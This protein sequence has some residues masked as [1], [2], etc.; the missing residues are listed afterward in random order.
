M[1]DVQWEELMDVY[2]FFKYSILDKLLLA[3]KCPKLGKHL[4]N[5]GYDN[6]SCR[7][8]TFLNPIH[9]KRI[10]KYNIYSGI[11]FYTNVSISTALQGWKEVNICVRVVIRCAYVT[12]NEFHNN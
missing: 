11:L 12:L 5:A 3:E 10:P 4:P 7:I 9:Q 2:I 1:T 6:Q 8:L